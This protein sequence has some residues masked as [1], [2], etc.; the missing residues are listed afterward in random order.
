M[1]GISI[2]LEITHQNYCN[3]IFLKWMFVLE[4][5]SSAVAIVGLDAGNLLDAFFTPS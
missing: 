1:F 4:G 2:H 3:L 5:K